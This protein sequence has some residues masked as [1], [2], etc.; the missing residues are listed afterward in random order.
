MLTGSARMAQEARERA[1]GLARQQQ[2]ARLKR[3]RERK[4]MAAHAQITAIKADLEG[5]VE[6]IDEN[7][8]EESAR[9]QTRARQSQ[10]M[11]RKRMADR[12]MQAA[13]TPDLRGNGGTK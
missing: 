5:D 10:A 8:A 2:I 4:A 12:E 6:E 1:V 3:A 13:A 11:G 9:A 7:L